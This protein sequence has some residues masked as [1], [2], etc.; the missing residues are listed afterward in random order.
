MFATLSNFEKK[1][2][3]YLQ[4]GRDL[5]QGINKKTATNQAW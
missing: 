5:E 1:V 4:F 2:Q 3:A